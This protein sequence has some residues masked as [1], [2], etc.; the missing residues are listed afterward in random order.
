MKLLSIHL[1]IHLTNRIIVKWPTS[2]IQNKA[3]HMFAWTYRLLYSGLAEKNQDLRAHHISF[4]LPASLPADPITESRKFC[5]LLRSKN[6]LCLKLLPSTTTLTNPTSKHD[7]RLAGGA[8]P[9]DPI[10]SGLPGLKGHKS[11]EC[12]KIH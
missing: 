7:S 5:F 2:T 8:G 3:G 10:G 6:S 9:L 11:L 4:Y 12:C 1:S